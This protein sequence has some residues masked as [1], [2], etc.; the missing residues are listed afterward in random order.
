MRRM[1]KPTYVAN[2]TVF[3]GNKVRK[4]QGV[5]F[6]TEGIEWI[7]A[8]SRPPKG[9]REAREVEGDGKTLMPG[10]IDVHVHLQ[11]DGDADFEKEAQGPHHPGVRGAE[12]DGQRETE[13][14][15]RRDHGP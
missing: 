9:A 14:G 6:G 3:D 13:P 12:G 15:R 7:G 2:V 11:F 5:L 4:R 8:H 1:A 10:L